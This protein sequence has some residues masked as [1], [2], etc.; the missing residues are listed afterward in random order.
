MHL[1][2]SDVS[3]KAEQRQNLWRQAVEGSRDQVTIGGLEADKGAS[4]F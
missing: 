3:I 4:W 1:E 2:F